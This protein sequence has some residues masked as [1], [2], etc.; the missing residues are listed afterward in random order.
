ME[1]IT[2]FIVAFSMSFLFCATINGILRDEDELTLKT[3][4]WITIPIFVVLEIVRYGL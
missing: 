2:L 3:A 4:G 1:H